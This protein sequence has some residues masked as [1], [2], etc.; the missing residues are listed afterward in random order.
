[1]KA[2]VYYLKYWYHFFKTGL[3]RGL[4]ASI[5]YGFPAKKLKI[6]AITG[7]DG[8]TT[9][10]TLMYEV[11]KAA[12]KKVA[13]LSTV[14]AYIG[15]E[16]I[17]TGLHVTS[18]DAHEL[19]KLMARMVKA[20]VEYLV[21][22]FT[23][24]GAYQNRLWGIRPLIAGVTN[25]THEHLDYHLTYDNYLEAKALVLRRSKVVVLNQDNQSYVK[26]R[27]SLADRVVLTYSAENSLPKKIRE[28]VDEK[29]PEPYNQMNA[30]LVTTIANHL[31]I[32]TATIAQGLWNFLGVDG[33]M[34]F[35]PNQ[36]GMEVVIDFAHTPNG[37]EEAMIALR[38]RMKTKGTNGRLIAVYGCAGLRD[39]TKRPMMGKIGIQ[40]ADLVVFTAEDPRTEDVWSIIR[41]MK[42]Q[43][44][45][46]QNQVVSI[47]DREMAINFAINKLAKRGDVVAFFGK[48]PEKSMCYGTTE[49][50]WSERA[51]VEQ[52][53]AKKK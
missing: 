4:P 31:K 8:K 18:P 16:K 43:L 20:G 5:R 7:T 24:H 13:L 14:A 21:L 30:R 22:E 1:M 45:S 11:L 38:K 53:L 47:A 36:R 15:S 35:V 48:G 2:L 9:S 44:T 37:L 17:E 50:P 41:Q 49:Y 29:L 27:K 42:E 40:Y 10:S 51:V 19:Q 26:L 46:G 52:A 6:V 28:V 3:L 23:S 33:R 12:G 32:P 25:I 39:Y 34:E